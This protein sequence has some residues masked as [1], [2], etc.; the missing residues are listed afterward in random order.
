MARRLEA[1]PVTLLLSLPAAG[2]LKSSA[3]RTFSGVALAAGLAEAGGA[4]AGAAET[5][6]A[7]D[8]LGD[9]EAEGEAAAVLEA[10]DAEL[11][12]ALG[13][14]LGT[15]LGTALTPQAAT[16]KPVRRTATVSGWGARTM[17]PRYSLFACVSWR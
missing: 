4:L 15:G 17:T 12:A 7:A 14:E 10:G 8:G 11:A 2:F 16:T 5:L 3:N 13:L 9:G 6:A 1:E